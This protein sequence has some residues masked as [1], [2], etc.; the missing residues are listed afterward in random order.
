MFQAAFYVCNHLNLTL[1]TELNFSTRKENIALKADLERF[2]SP[3]TGTYGMEGLPISE[4]NGKLYHFN[5]TKS[6]YLPN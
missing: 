2:V 5:S 3:K 4:F 1:K 6:Y